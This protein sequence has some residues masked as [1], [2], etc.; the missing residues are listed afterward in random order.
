MSTEVQDILNRYLKDFLD[1]YALTAHQ[2]KV[3]NDIIKCRTEALGGHAD[4][5]DKCGYIEISYNSCR[6]RHCPKCQTYKKEKWIDARKE[7]LLPVP[8]FHTVFTIPEQLNMIMHQNQEEMYKILFAA[9]SGTLS[10]LS[11]DPKH[12]GAQIG[13]T[14][15]LHTWGQNIMYHPH[16]H[17]IV[18]GGGVAEDGSIKLC[19]EDFF[20]YVKV[21]SRKFRGKFMDMLKKIRFA[22]D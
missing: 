21:L 6:N 12:L 4:K 14:C 17:C 13:F 11:A 8:Y 22:H 5:C 1:V 18:A 19:E 7:D 10:E 3:V 15:I 16:L 2:Y 20:I 9:V